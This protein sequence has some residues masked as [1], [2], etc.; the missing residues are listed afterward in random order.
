MATLLTRVRSDLDRGN[1]TVKGDKG[2]AAKRNKDRTVPLTI[3][4]QQIL[5]NRRPSNFQPDDPT[6][7]HRLFLALSPIFTV[8]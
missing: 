8:F 3:E 5:I 6:R 2:K 1:E 7:T 4:L